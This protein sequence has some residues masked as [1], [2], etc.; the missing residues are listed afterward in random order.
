MKAAQTK[1]CDLLAAMIFEN[2]E[3]TKLALSIP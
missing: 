1:G 2:K 3:I